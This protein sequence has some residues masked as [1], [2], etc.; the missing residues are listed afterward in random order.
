[1]DRYGSLF[2]YEKDF[3]YFNYTAGYVAESEWCRVLRRET[4][5]HRWRFLERH[6]EEGAC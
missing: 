6:I 2:L 4:Y 5:I 1:M 3:D